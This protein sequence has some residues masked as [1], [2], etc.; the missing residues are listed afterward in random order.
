MNRIPVI[1]ILFFLTACSDNKQEI[2]KIEKSSIVSD[3]SGAEI[4]I[5]YFSNGNRVDNELTTHQGYQLIFDHSK[6][7]SSDPIT[8]D[9]LTNALN[10]EITVFNFEKVS[11]RID[12]LKSTIQFLKNNEKEILKEYANL[13]L[14]YLPQEYSQNATLFYVIGG[15]NG[16][17]M[18]DKICINIDYKPFRK[19]YNEIKLYI[20]HELFHIGFEKYHPLPDILGAKKVKDLKEIVLSMTMNEGLA[21]LTPFQKRIEINELNDYDYEVLLDSAKLNQK[22]IQ[23]NNVMTFL[24]NNLEKEITNE[25]LGKV[26]GQCS[27]D[28]LFYIVGCHMGLTIEKEYG[29]SEIVQLI[30]KDP[31]VF[32]KTYNKIKVANTVY[33][34]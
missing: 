5:N 2:I 9:D 16:I 14:K 11:T 10:G 18:N 17:A 22:L 13:P 24:D 1:L 15:Y 25:I 31:K 8:K 19:N 33:S 27:G 3:H 32:F 7:Y 21:T 6:K 30:K 34:K 23:F 4:L 26:L 20:A 28:R 12:S 29:A